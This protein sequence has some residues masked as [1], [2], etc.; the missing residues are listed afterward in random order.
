MRA[1]IV[2]VALAAAAA[3]TA[4]AAETWQRFVDPAATFSVE[5][6]A[7]FSFTR[8]DTVSGLPAR[9]FSARSGDFAYVIVAMDARSLP[10]A[11]WTMGADKI[12]DAIAT[13]AAE[14]QVLVSRRALPYPGGAAHEVVL[15]IDGVASRN[16][17]IVRRPYILNV[18]VMRN[19]S[20]TGSLQ[21]PDADRFLRTTA[22]AGPAT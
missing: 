5:A 22:V 10:A 6:P 3:T 15:V 7:S 2:A 18:A 1:L 13:G 4:L 19:G 16:L 11:E 9:A 12:A 20:D 14:G 8:N 21:N 17:F